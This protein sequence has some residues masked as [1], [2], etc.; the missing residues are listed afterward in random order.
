MRQLNSI[1]IRLRIDRLP[2]KGVVLSAP[3]IW[4][5]TGA[6]CLASSVSGGCNTRKSRLGHLCLQ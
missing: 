4:A 2:S 5:G 1:S 6:T 3:Y